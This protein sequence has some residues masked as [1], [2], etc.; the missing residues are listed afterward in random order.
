MSNYLVFGIGKSGLA[1]GEMLKRKGKTVY[2]TKDTDFSKKEIQEIIKLK[3]NYLQFEKREKLIK[4]G[5][6]DVVVL[7]PAISLS[8]PLVKLAKKYK[9]KVIGELELAS[10]Y[11]RGKIVA[12][13][14]TNGKTT[15]T[16]LITHILKTAGKSCYAVGNI[17]TAF[18]TI[19]DKIEPNEIAVVETSS[20]QL[21]SVKNFSPDIAVLL[22][23]S[24]DHINRHKTIENYIE[25]KSNIFLYQKK[26][27]KLIANYD[28]GIVKEIV[29]DRNPIW[30]SRK[31]KL[32]GCYIEGENIFTPNGDYVCSTSTIKLIGSH[33]LENTLASILVAIELGIKVEYILKGISTF[34][35]PKHRLQ[36]VKNIDGID[37]YNDSKATNPSA[38][39]VAVN[40][41]GD[42]DIILILGGRGEFNFLELLLNLPENV[43]RIVV[44]GE[45]SELII[46]AL[47]KVT[48]FEY[49]VATTL[50]EAVHIARFFAK[51][52]NVILFSPAS[53]SFDMYK[54]FEVRGENFISILE[55]IDETK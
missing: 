21:E 27:C 43:R 25:A 55:K 52:K 1:V 37:Y 2:Y 16:Q 30:F 12:I 28:D 41:M 23:I 22:N 14:G 8:H 15:T 10:K 50:E 45:N 6:I 24:N 9:V 11:C 53:K 32:N 40:A 46:K 39:I 5:E 44:Y 18:S 48:Y 19:A 42:K 20:F 29:N 49:S 26:G 47:E 7:S 54:S 35:A 36:F 4:K 31:E 34:A 13:T 3:A 38:T 33:N 51:P 17:G